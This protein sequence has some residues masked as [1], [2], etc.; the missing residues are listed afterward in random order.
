[1]KINRVPFIKMNR[2]FTHF[3][4][5]LGRPQQTLPSFWVYMILALKSL[6]LADLW[7]SRPPVFIAQM[8][9]AKKPSYFPLKSWLVYRDPHIWLL[10]NPHINW[11]G[12][13]SPKTNLKQPRAHF[14]LLLKWSDKKLSSDLGVIFRFLRG[15]LCCHKG[16][17]GSLGGFLFQMCAF[18][19]CVFTQIFRKKPLKKLRGI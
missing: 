7:T 6:K 8:S 4:K 14:F 11:V 15:F 18:Q 17:I 3:Y 16:I 19:M 1:M 13:S 12:F 2:L 5:S 10:K 9:Y